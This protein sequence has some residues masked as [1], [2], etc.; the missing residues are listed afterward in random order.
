MVTHPPVAIYDPNDPRIAGFRSVRDADLRGRDG[1]FCVE[2]PRVVRRF[3]HALV[4]RSRGAAIAPPVQLQSLLVT[5]EIGAQLG[6]LLDEAIAISR[7]PVAIYHA[8]DDV[9]S[10]I[11][12]YGMH[13][14]ALAL[15]I[16]PA[17]TSLTSMLAAMTTEQ[18][19]LVACGVVLTD[20]IGALFRNAGSFGNCGILL[21][22]GSSDP[23]HRK[24]IRISAGRVFS[25]PW[26]YST[27]W[28]GDL[29]KLRK[30]HGFAVIA[31]EDTPQ[32]V[33][34]EDFEKFPVLTQRKR[35]A[36]VLG[37][38]GAGVSKDV[39]DACDGTCV[40]PM[41]TPGRL[42]E[43]GDRPSLNVAVASALFLHRLACTNL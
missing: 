13:K 38:E 19:L 42:I 40:I 27:D 4:E 6:D 33:S 7:D 9:M 3:L 26:G 29:D 23:L 8:P 25:V 15:G 1:Q 11:S 21:A 41:R 39:L 43:L 36:I 37:A 10:G 20:N 16:R 34:L 22:G 14:G 28:P 2:S 5:P 12:G 17:D 35:V 24:S 30:V 32:A 31:A 18:H